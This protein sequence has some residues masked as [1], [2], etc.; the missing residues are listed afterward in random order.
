[1]AGSESLEKLKQEYKL[2]DDQVEAIQKL[3]NPPQS[4]TKVEPGISES[5]L[6]NL[7]KEADRYKSAQR[8]VTDALGVLW[9]SQLDAALSLGK[10]ESIERSLGRMVA[11]WDNCNCGGGGGPACW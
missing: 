2:A 1:M 5:Q 7:R 6:T 11:L 9:N 8:Q 4:E 3:L 10:A